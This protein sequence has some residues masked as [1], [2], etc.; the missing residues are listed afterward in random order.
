MSETKVKPKAELAKVRAALKP[1]KPKTA[2]SK[3]KSKSEQKLQQGQARQAYKDVKAKVFKFEQENRKRIVI[4]KNASDWYKIGGNS[5]IFYMH[6]VA[7]RLKLT[8]TPR[9]D[10]DYHSE[11]EGG[12]WSFRDL[13][14][15]EARLKK[16]GMHLHNFGQGWRSYNLGFTVTQSELEA[17]RKEEEMR[18]QRLNQVVMPVSSYPDLYAWLRGVMKTVTDRQ[19]RMDKA[20]QPAL[21]NRAA[22]W[23]V[24]MAQ[25]Y[26]LMANGK[27]EKKKFFTE[28]GEWV[29][30]MMSWVMVMEELRQMKM[31]TCL[32]LGGTLQKI[33]QMV[34]ESGVV[35]RAKVGGEVNER[36]RKRSQS[37][38][39]KG[40]QPE[41]LTL[42]SVTTRTK[43]AE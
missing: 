4:F 6:F 11:F 26:I 19:R 24:A 10:T 5:L 31:T 21:G 1:A 22:E 37:V 8:V 34:Q 36:V 20:L 3:P 13:E 28:C 14:E 33:R 35:E 15:F 12:V 27:M 2:K 39:K 18:W 16:V 7:K 41:Q 42:Q 17:I 30:W 40:K 29:E 9:Q 25:S 43:D 38:T 23:T 32:Q